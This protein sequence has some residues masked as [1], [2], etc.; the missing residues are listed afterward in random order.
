MMWGTSAV[1]QHKN[2][3]IRLIE[4]VI[5]DIEI[6]PDCRLAVISGEYEGQTGVCC[7][8]VSDAMLKDWDEWDFHEHCRQVWREACE[9]KQRELT[10]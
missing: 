5:S 1:I 6:P 3:R 10:Q 9:D 7:F 8:L 4:H 2:I